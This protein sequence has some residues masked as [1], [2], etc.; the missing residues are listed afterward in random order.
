M[1]LHVI[2]NTTVRFV[3]PRGRNHEEMTL[4]FETKQDR[5]DWICLFCQIK[6]GMGPTSDHCINPDNYTEQEMMDILINWA[7]LFQRFIDR[8]GQSQVPKILK[9]A[10]ARS[11]LPIVLRERQDQH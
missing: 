6:D 1:S 7:G 4:Q 8:F 10:A 9:E 2:S 3:D 11:P 5:D